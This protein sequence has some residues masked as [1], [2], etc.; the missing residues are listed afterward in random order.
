MISDFW[1]AGKWREELD[2]I[3]LQA[4]TLEGRDPWR[5]IAG[6]YFYKTAVKRI[7]TSLSNIFNLFGN[8]GEG[9][10]RMTTSLLF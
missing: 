6:L 2:G 5:K 1:R 3:S 8:E 10:E 7:I 4:A 9:R